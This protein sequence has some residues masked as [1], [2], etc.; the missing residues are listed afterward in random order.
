MRRADEFRAE[1]GFTMIEILMVLLIMGILAAIAIPTFFNQREKAQDSD[2]KLVAKTAQTAMETWGADHD[3]D[4]TP[5]PTPAQ[6]QAIDDTLPAGLGISG[7]SAN[8]YTVTASSDSGR[9]FSVM[10]AGSGFSH[11]C[12]A[13]GGGCPSGLDWGG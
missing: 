4:Y 9:T 6:L 7:V 1:N 3:G 8:G 11:P 5:A 10:R 13:T 12:S 2:A